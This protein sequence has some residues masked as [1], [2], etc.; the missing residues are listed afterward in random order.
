LLA[1]ANADFPEFGTLL[2]RLRHTYDKPVA[3]VIYGGEAAGRWTADLEGA[4][5][6]IFK[7][8]RAAVRALALLVQ[9]TAQ[10]SDPSPDHLPI[11]DN[12]VRA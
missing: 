8:T 12:A 2:R 1:P 9:A 11:S 5:I 6:P 3:M 4:D 10:I 7:S